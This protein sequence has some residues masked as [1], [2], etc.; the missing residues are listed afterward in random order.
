ML[1]YTDPYECCDVLLLKESWQQNL[2]VQVLEP[3]SNTM[4]TILLQH[5]HGGRRERV[6]SLQKDET[7]IRNAT[8]QRF[9]SSTELILK[10]DERNS[11]DPVLLLGY[12]RR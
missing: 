4:P 3:G 8:Q 2:G 10:S 9:L 1:S 6:T 5:R 11:V 12:L 7:L